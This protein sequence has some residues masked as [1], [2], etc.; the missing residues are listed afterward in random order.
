M[1]TEKVTTG[2]NS[3]KT[4]SK[5]AIHCPFC[6]SYITPDYLFIH[7]GTLLA[8]CTNSHCARHFLLGYN[9]EA[10]FTVIIRNS[11]PKQREFSE[12]IHTVSPSFEEIYNQA[13]CAEQM[14]LQHI[15]G[16][17]YRK[18]LE[19]L[20]KDYLM[21]EMEDESEKERIKSKFLGA[22]INDD[23]KSEKIKAVAKRAAWL[24]NDETHY[25]RKWENKDVSDLKRLIDLTLHW[26]ESEIETKKLLEDMPE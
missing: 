15:C 10:E 21:S 5:V 26:I 9:S 16:V 23:V 8:Q 4:V 14:N 18:S 24:G 12:V 3:Y 17:G 25:N 2:L 13:Y 22:C 7:S 6:K 20:I 19:F 11:S 1:S